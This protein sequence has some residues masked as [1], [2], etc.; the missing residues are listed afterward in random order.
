M[1]KWFILLSCLLALGLSG[2]L[3]GQT[4]SELL[5][6]FSEM[7]ENVFKLKYR[8]DYIKALDALTDGFIHLTRV[9]TTAPDDLRATLAAHGEVYL[10]LLYSLVQ[11]TA[12]YRDLEDALDEIETEAPTLNAAVQH[13]RMRLN[14]HLGQIEEARNLKQ[15]LGYIDTWHLIGP[16]DNERGGAFNTVY[17]PEKSIDLGAEYD[18][19]EH[20]V[21]W[22]LNPRASLTGYIDLDAI[23]T[24]DDQCLGYALAFLK[25]E[26]E[27]DVCLR[28]GSDEAIKI[29]F[30]GKVVYSMD[31]RRLH[32]FDQ[33]VVGLHLNP[34]VNVI[35][36]KICDQTGSWGFSAR[37]TSPSGGAVSG[38]EIVADP[39]GLTLAEASGS[40]AIIE[41]DA[42]ARSHFEALAR[43]G[44]RRAHLY[45][46][47]LHLKREYEGED[48]GLA[49]D[50]LVAFL[51]ENPDHVYA[52]YLK[53]VSELRRYYIAA[54]RDV[55]P[56]RVGLERAIALD[57][58]NVECRVR[59]GQHYLSTLMIPDRAQAHALAAYE[60]NEDFLP[61]SYLFSD[62]Y[63]AKEMPAR[64][65]KVIMQLSHSA[66]N[67]EF[68]GLL[69]RLGDI[70]RSEK[71]IED[72]GKLYKKALDSDFL[73]DSARSKLLSMALESGDVE[74]AR[75]LHG[76]R[77]ELDPYDIPTL[78]SLAF[79]ALGDEKIENAITYLQ[80]VLEINPEDDRALKV[81]GDVH[82]RLARDDEALE[83]Y[84]QAL[85]FNPK[86]KELRRYVEFLFEA[87]RPF[88]DD[89]E[90]DLLA[91]V[92]SNP[93]GDNPDNDSHEYLLLQDVI[94]VN[95]DGT[96]S[97]Y[98]H[99]IA[100]I[101]N[102]QGAKRFDY[103]STWYAPNEQ[104]CR[105]KTARIIHPDGSIE[106][107]KIDNRRRRAPA[108]RELVPAGVDLPT[109]K[110]GDLVDVEYRTDDLKQSFFGDYFGY[111]HFFQA[112]DLKTV[113]DSR[114]TIILPA[115]REFYFNQNNLDTQPDVTAD[116]EKG[117]KTRTWFL[118]NI[119]KIDPERYMPGRIENCPYVEVTTYPNWDEFGNWWWNLVEEQLDLSE[120]MRAKVKELTEGLSTAREKLNAIYKFV[121]SD[122]RYNDTWEFGVH[123][124]KP[125]K[126]SAI[127]SNRFGDCKDK[128]ILLKAL[129]KEVGIDAFPV[130]IRA[131]VQ[132]DREDLTL[133]MVSHFN[134]VI[135]Y[136]PELDGEKVDL[137]LDGTAQFHPMEVLPDMDRGA[138]VFVV[139]H[140]PGK[141]VEIPYPD[142]GKNL[143]VMAFDVELRSDGS[144]LITMDAQFHGT[145]EPLTRK[146]FLN[147]GK[148]KDK[149]AKAFGSVFG[150]VSV[151]ETRFTD[152]EDLDKPMRYKATI[153]AK[154]VLMKSSEGMQLRSVF[155]PSE[156]GGL[157]AEDEREFDLLLS[158]PN[159]FNS[160]IYYKLPE[161]YAASMLPPTT[162]LE[163]DFAA[164]S[165][166]FAK[167]EGNKV[168][169]QRD[170]ILKKARIA[171][172]DYEAFRD[173]CR[174]AERAEEKMIQI[175]KK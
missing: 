106:E 144:A 12:K 33:D 141:I 4:P 89:F 160:T 60:A 99:M 93:L 128:S 16:F 120:E 31:A 139:R 82:H 109:L 130:L 38:V 125:Y 61:A 143:Q 79:M 95:V 59:L 113:F 175:T 37:L 14:M 168:K 161:G 90:V 148:R 132:R 34:G 19:K 115:K 40:P 156:I 158:V 119:P 27:K 117:T 87:E 122:I 123:G 98:H 43:K 70:A 147:P 149:L 105:I 76:E 101:L 22:R 32:H 24:P 21:S 3:Y 146:N 126:C 85:D 55:N 152:V 5:D 11:K 77:L 80:Q 69:M 114:L 46:G 142:A 41:V 124:F 48:Q 65:R 63:E 49:T 97:H 62:V 163:N 66:K 131:E 26:E 127:F 50:H 52:T 157:A 35:L 54:E 154:N 162:K 155:F 17:G 23:F 57:P 170:L 36:L 165:L 169:V 15:G 129:L 135:S 73:A 78:M 47:Y 25:S 173:L 107:A 100:R 29:Y 58:N 42:G 30:N 118:S 103:Y 51:I 140:G 137:F 88:E 7:E 94:K 2:Q 75:R 20:T 1:K 116:E 74:E 9:M 81:M 45:L 167:G 145:F 108:G 133:P 83:Y 53:A 104:K 174:E 112:D 121:V 138:K 72:A 96:S 110:P 102:Q 28:V 111:K 171:A 91:L 84:K 10:E 151:G 64:S 71:R 8:G 153:E 13:V 6:D 86:N 136:V 159:A 164:F 134:H 150:D 44:E 67:L 166:T 18:G 39:G 172:T 56:W 92:A 68:P